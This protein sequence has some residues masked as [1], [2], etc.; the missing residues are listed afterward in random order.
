METPDA[1]EHI[2]DWEVLEGWST[3]VDHLRY[4][5]GIDDPPEDDGEA[6]RLHLS[7]HGKDDDL[8]TDPENEP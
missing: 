4:G 8:E 2:H 1:P 5:H 6:W 3:F 7:L